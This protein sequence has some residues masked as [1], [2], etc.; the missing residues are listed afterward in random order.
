MPPMAETM[1]QWRP[2][3]PR[4]AAGGGTSGRAEGKEEGGSQ[5]EGRRRGEDEEEQLSSL[6]HSLEASRCFSNSRSHRCPTRTELLARV[7][8]YRHARGGIALALDV[9]E[10]PVPSPQH[11]NEL[12]A[13]FKWWPR[14]S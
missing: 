9:F 4:R 3:V 13:Q 7:T 12:L 6:V 5:E 2:A 8:L 11:K 10:T 14:R 1:A